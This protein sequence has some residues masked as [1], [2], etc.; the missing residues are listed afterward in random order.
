MRQAATLLDVC[1]ATIHEW[2]RQGVTR[3]YEARWAGL[4]EE[5]RGAWSRNAVSKE[6][7][8]REF[9]LSGR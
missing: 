5:G 2:K 8:V 7:E 1:V 9:R 6:C 3:L 4:F